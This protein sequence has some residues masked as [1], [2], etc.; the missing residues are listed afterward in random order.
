MHSASSVSLI[1]PNS[2]LVFGVDYRN[3]SNYFIGTMENVAFY[4]QSLTDSQVNALYE[5]TVV[6]FPSSLPSPL[7]STRI[8][9]A[10]PTNSTTSVTQPPVQTTPSTTTSSS[11]GGSSSS[12]KS[13]CIIQ[14][15]VP[16]V[17]AFLIGLCA[18]GVAYHIYQLQK[19]DLDKRAAGTA[20]NT[21]NHT[22]RPAFRI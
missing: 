13:I 21:A 7:A 18:C 6:A 8:P 15:V 14:I 12:C 1:Y 19:A 11:G 5:S 4:S 17:G 2:K 22:G 20:A 3:L 16:L 10:R 9:S